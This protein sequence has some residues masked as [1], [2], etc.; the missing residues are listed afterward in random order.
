MDTRADC[1]ASSRFESPPFEEYA[2]LS[3]FRLYRTMALHRDASAL[4]SWLEQTAEYKSTM[5]KRHAKVDG[6]LANARG[7][8]Q[9]QNRNCAGSNDMTGSEVTTIE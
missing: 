2:F 3:R 1:R 5:I 7:G 9:T 4:A 8:Q 6:P